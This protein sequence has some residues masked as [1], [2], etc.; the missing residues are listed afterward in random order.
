[1]DD[2]GTVDCDFGGEDI[3]LL[4]TSVPDTLATLQRHIIFFFSFFKK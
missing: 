3:I 2:G 4:L 1:M